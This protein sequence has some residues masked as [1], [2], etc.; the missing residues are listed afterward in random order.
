MQ[1]TCN[2]S[3]AYHV[4]QVVLHATWH[5]WTAQI[6]S[7]QNWNRIYL[8]SILL[9]EPLTNEGGEETGVPRENPWQR[10]S[11]S[12]H[13]WQPGPLHGDYLKSPICQKLLGKTETVWGTYRLSC[14]LRLPNTKMSK[15]NKPRWMQ[16]VA[17]VSHRQICKD[18]S[19]CCNTKIKIADQTCF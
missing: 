13:I 18:N 4:Q 8:S 12:P 2:T 5:N 7:W 11:W 6:L 3:S 16:L 14:P 1:I 9:A 10:A 15:M 17:S 19:I